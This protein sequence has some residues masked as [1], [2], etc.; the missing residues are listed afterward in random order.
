VTLQAILN[1]AHASFDH[2][3]LNCDVWLLVRTYCRGLLGSDELERY[4]E[5]CDKND[6]KNHQSEWEDLLEKFDPDNEFIDAGRYDFVDDFEEKAEFQLKAFSLYLEDKPTE[7][8]AYRRFLVS[9]FSMVLATIIIFMIIISH[10]HSIG[11][12]QS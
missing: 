9:I 2:F 12:L 10:H 11:A 3:E 4:R 1:C 7:L 8:A 6:D 5:L